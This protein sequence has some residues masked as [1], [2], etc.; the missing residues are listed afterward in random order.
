MLNGEIVNHL[1][2]NN[3]S[4]TNVDDIA[5]SVVTIINLELADQEYVKFMDKIRNFSK[6]LTNRWQDAQRIQERFFKRN[7]KWLNNDFILSITKSNQSCLESS[8]SD[9]GR[10]EEHTSELQSRFDLVYRFL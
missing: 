7:N 9:S 10:S 2:E 3:I 6:N 5:N 8:Q 1:F 4:F